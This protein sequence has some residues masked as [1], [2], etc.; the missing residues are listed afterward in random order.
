MQ[1]KRQPG[2]VFSTQRMVVAA[3]AWCL[4][5]PVLFALHMLGQVKAGWTDGV[6]RPFGEDFINFWS[7]A[8]LAITQRVTAIY[9]IAAFHDFQV[10]VVG[11]AIDLYHYSYPPVLPLLMA[12]FGLLPYPIAWVAWQVLGWL[13]FA[14]A[15][16]RMAPNYWVLAALAWPAV[17]INALGGQAGCWIAAIVG[18]G[19]VLLP[20]RPLIAGLLL[21][22]LVIKPQIAWLVPLALLAGREWRAL[23][24]ITVG[25]VALLA[26]TTLVFGI[27]IWPEYAHQAQLLKRVILE[28]GSGTWHRMISIFVLVRH[29]GAPLFLAYGA[30]AVVSLATAWIVLT[31]WYRGSPLRAHFLIVGMLVGSIYVSD[32]DCV[33][34]AFPALALWQRLSGNGRMVIVLTASIPLV[35]ATIAVATG[36]AVGALMLWPILAALH[37]LD[38][39]SPSRYPA[40]A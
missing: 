12:P 19:L 36:V 38:R 33:L 17:L 10:G 39:D 20:R 35:A 15:L 30:Q 31:A 22:L 2:T 4:V 5:W 32:Y 6:D 37:R 26:A 24:G 16:R 23:I 27:T 8:R 3:W 28:D 7:A 34:L 14:T 21:S 13:A 1:D 11:H 18:W 25:G 40:L 9:D 29:L